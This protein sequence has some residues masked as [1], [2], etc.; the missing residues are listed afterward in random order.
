MASCATALITV[1]ILAGCGSSDRSGTENYEVR[2]STTISAA[3]PP[4]TRSQFVRRVNKICREAW[5]D[6][7]ENWGTYVADLEPDLSVKE[8]FATA[9]KGPLLA[10]IDFYIFD[11]IRIL[12]SP[13]GD[14]R[15]IEQMIGPF[16]AAV[17]LGQMGRWRAY[18]P[19]E[20][21][22]HFAEYNRRARQH[23]LDACLVTEAHL[24]PLA[25]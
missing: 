24:G 15:P 20:I 25:V 22:P 11:A 2:A 6:V 7:R 10:G 18:A 19:A 9:L 21:P 5:A 14:E 3:Q 23:G 4:L 16:Q 17:E 8:R 13:A 1:A 12:G